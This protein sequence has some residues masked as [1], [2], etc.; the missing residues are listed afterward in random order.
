MYFKIEN[1]GCLVER[2]LIQVTAK[3]VAKDA[4]K[5][6]VYINDEKVPYHRYHVI[7]FS[8]VQRN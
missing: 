2:G 6:Y 7:Y 5:N 8:N 4:E 1:S 3:Y